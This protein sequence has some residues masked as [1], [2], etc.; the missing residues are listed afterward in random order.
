MVSLLLTLTMQMLSKYLDLCCNLSRGVFGTLSNI[1]DRVFLPK[2]TS[3]FYFST[4]LKKKKTPSET[5][6][7]ILDINGF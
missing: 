5:F 2:M 7:W 6:D 1:S 3:K 4:I